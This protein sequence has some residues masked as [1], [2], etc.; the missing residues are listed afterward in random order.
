MSVV[1]E[2]DFCRCQSHG[3]AEALKATF[4]SGIFQVL[5]TADSFMVNCNHS[6]DS[7]SDSS[8]AWYGA[9]AS[10]RLRTYSPQTGIQPG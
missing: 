1:E 3:V 5:A 8:G 4:E 10:K 7:R 2:W 6:V 9:A